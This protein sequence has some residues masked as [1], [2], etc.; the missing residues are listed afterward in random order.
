MDTRRPICFRSSQGAAVVRGFLT[1]FVPDEFRPGEISILE[2]ALEDAWRRVEESKAPWA[3]DGYSI[4]GRTILARHIIKMAQGGERDPRWLA[5]SALLYLSQ[6][7]L[8]R[9]PPEGL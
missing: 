8:T 4:V 9:T 5:D 2:D 3:S 6:Q 1:H 7:K